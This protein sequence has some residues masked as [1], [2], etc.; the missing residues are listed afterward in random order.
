MPEMMKSGLVSTFQ[1]WRQVGQKPKSTQF[2]VP[3]PSPSS[4]MSRKP[5]KIAA[6]SRLTGSA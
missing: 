4:P 6:G 5:L 1:M 3:K 2:S